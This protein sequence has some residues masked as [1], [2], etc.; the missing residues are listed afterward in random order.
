MLRADFSKTPGLA[1]NLP[2]VV[3]KE[4]IHR[5]AEALVAQMVKNLPG[6]AG[7]PGSIPVSGRS[8]GEG[9]GYPLQYSGLENSMDRRAWRATIYG[10]AKWS[11]WG[12]QG[13][14]GETLLALVS[15]DPD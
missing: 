13:E 12:K 8:L 15:S 10:V 14:K 9:N 3:P 5:Q 11:L 4:G 1:G 2:S 7:D 6:H